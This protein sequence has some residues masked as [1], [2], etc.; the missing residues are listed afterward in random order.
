MGTSDSPRCG[1]DDMIDREVVILLFVLVMV[2]ITFK[3]T[4]GSAGYTFLLRRLNI[5]VPKVLGV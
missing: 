5:T 4:L 3:R 1:S 2:V